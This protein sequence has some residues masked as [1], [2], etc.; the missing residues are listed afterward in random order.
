MAE[1]VACS[2][3]IERILV[4]RLIYYPLIRQERQ[5]VRIPL[6]QDFRVGMA[7]VNPTKSADPAPTN[8]VAFRFW[9]RAG[10][11][12]GIAGG[13]PAAWDNRAGKPRVPAPNAVHF[14]H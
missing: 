14:S 11:C 8:C 10:D 3:P 6:G 13:V 5:V 9:A 4:R 1:D 2:L 12:S 7:E